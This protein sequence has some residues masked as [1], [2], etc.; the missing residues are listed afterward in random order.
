M[1]FDNYFSALWVPGIVFDM[2]IIADLYNV[3]TVKVIGKAAEL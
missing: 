3:E 1:W 2:Q